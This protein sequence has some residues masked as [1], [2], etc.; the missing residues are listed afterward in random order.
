MEKQQCKGDKMML[1][2]P[3]RIVDKKLIKSM[4][5]QP[6]LKC[7]KPTIG[8]P[9]HIIPVGAG[10]PDIPENLAPLNCSDAHHQKAHENKITR[11]ELF[12]LKAAEMGKPIEV[13]EDIVHRARRFY[14]YDYGN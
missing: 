13:I 14:E 9:H 1:G 2:K 7:G 4:S 11:A 8:W 12:A 6:C 5:N 10:G 3:H